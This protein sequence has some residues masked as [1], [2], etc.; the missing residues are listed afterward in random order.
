[1]VWAQYI[2]TEIT[3][4]AKIGVVLRAQGTSAGYLMY[5]NAIIF[6]HKITVL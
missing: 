5:G 2:K 4:P 3:C 1:V 6:G